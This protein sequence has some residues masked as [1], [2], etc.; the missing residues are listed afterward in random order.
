MNKIK[1]KKFKVKNLW[2][3]PC[4][5]SF[6]FSACDN[7]FKNDYND[8]SP[9]SGKLKVYYSEGLQ[10]HVKNQASTFLTDYH[11]AKIECIPACE[12]EIVNGLLN[13]SCKAIIIS[14]L[15]N[16]QETKAFA[17]KN[18]QPMHSALA[19]SGVAL[20]TSVSTDIDKLNVEQVKQLLSAELTV[21]DS[22]G[23]PVS[24]LAVL[25]SKCSSVSHYLQDSI[26]GSKKFGP[27][28]FAANNALELLQKITEQKDQIGFIDFA[29][30]SDVDDSLYIA[31][32]NKI[33]FIAIGR[34]DTIFFAPN[35]SSFKTGEYPF[36]RTIYLL[37]RS[38][39]FSLAKGFEAYLAGPKGQMTFL[40][41]G[42]LPIRQSERKIEVNTKPLGQ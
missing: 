12:A 42:L 3:V 24:P 15:L 36:T 9:T 29:W 7:Y 4:I 38:S 27:K 23:H 26:I 22:A 28:C 11:E 20:I 37:R 2:L 18:L 34:T 30:L 40:K 39:D 35:Q 19:K 1:N 25:D 32:K 31:Y 5:F 8:N 21:K 16:E 33:K 14:R 13:D 41:Q 10:L 17:Q 6:I